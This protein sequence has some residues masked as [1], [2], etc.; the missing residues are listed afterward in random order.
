MYRTAHKMSRTVK[1]RCKKSKQ[2]RRNKSRKL[3]RGKSPKMKFTKAIDH[4]KKQVLK[5][6]PSTVGDA[7]K[8][9]LKS[10][11]SLKKRISANRI[12]KIP[13]TGGL[14]PL[15][16][17]FAGLSALGSLT[18][19]AAAIAKV[20]NDAKA[21]RNQLSESQRHNKTMES[22]AI[23]KGIYMRPYKSGLGLFLHPSKN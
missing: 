3:K 11:K 15:I 2:K 16:P 9:A 20:V 12:V 22:I 8:I 14:L 1:S 17:I 19:S 21:A 6:K 7:I 10:A 4:I 18:G 13:K 5:G 23:G